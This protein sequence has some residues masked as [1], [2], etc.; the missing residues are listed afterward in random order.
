MRIANKGKVMQLIDVMIKGGWLMIP[1]SLCSVFSL[2]IILE[3]LVR[4]NRIRGNI[5]KITQ[6]L[7]PLIVGN[8]FSEA[9]LLCEESQG[10]ISRL[11][12]VVLQE[13][14]KDSQLNRSVDEEIGLTQRIIDEEIQVTIIPSLERRLNALDT[15]ARGTPLLG[16]L[17]TVIGMIK[18]F[19]T[20]GIGQSA[21]D[22]ALLARG[23]GLALITTAAGLIVAIPS[24][25]MHRYF[26]G[27][28]DHLVTDAQKAKVWFI[29]QL[30]KRHQISLVGAHEE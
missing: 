18:V 13:L 23:I 29:G 11:F 5:K 25:F 1:I 28:V 15:L 27:R 21:P 2:G 26:Q 24:F 16:L 10:V 6:K 17:G 14:Q 22:P 19:F 4:Y 8:K 3:R 9:S 7:A 12:L 20:L 30:A